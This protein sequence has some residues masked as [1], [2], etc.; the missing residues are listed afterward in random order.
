[1]NVSNETT[2][3]VERKRHIFVGQNNFFQLS[4]FT[5]QNSQ[6]NFI[7]KMLCFLLFPFYVYLVG[8]LFSLKKLIS[9]AFSL[10]LY[11]IL[12]SNLPH[13]LHCLRNRT[14]VERYTRLL[15]YV[16]SFSDFN[17]ISH[18]IT[19]NSHVYE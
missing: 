5:F 14:Y 13:L 16:R 8:N 7:S 2:Q 17:H 11:S 19:C 1:M 9:A 12:M 6:T 18:P 4:L 15:Q 3:F 10:P